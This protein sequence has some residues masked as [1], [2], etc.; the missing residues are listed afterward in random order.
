M[1]HV[2]L[3][4]TLRSKCNLSTAKRMH[5]DLLPCRDTV[6]GEDRLLSTADCEPGLGVRHFARALPMLNARVPVWHAAD[7]HAAA[8]GAVRLEDGQAGPD[9]EY[10][11]L[12]V[13]ANGTWG[14]VCGRQ[15]FTTSTA[16]VACKSLGYGGGAPLRFCQPCVRRLGGIEHDVRTPLPALQV[17][18]NTSSKQSLLRKQVE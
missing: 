9:F 2:V 5:K 3:S 11:R 10:G 17:L 16:N 13:F 15:K 6:V 8:D 1:E 14:S 18:R 7:V 12:E 4:G